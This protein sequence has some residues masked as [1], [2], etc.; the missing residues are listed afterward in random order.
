MSDIPYWPQSLKRSEEIGAGY[1]LQDI[2]LLQDAT[3]PAEDWSQVLEGVRPFLV[4]SF[5]EDAALADA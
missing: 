2:A 3:T 1:L 5:T 4:E